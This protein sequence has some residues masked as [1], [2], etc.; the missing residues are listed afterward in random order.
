MC[1]LKAGI[2]TMTAAYKDLGYDTHRLQ[3]PDLFTSKSLKSVLKSPVTAN[4]Y[5]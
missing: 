4:A 2:F 3:R 5:L 1:I